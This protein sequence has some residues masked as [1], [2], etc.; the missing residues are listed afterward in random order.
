ME[1]SEPIPQTDAPVEPAKPLDYVGYGPAYPPPMRARSD[2]S[3]LAIAVGV[4]SIV[5]AS[6]GMLVNGYGLSTYVD[7]YR[8]SIPPPPPAPPTPLPPVQF[9][10]YDGDCIGPSGIKAPLRD[11]VLVAWEKSADEKLSN[12]RKAMLHRILADAGRDAFA[13]AE[14]GRIAAEVRE[15]G[16]ANKGPDGEGVLGTQYMITTRGRID[17]NNSTAYF[18]P[19]ASQSPADGTGSGGDAGPARAKVEG[20]VFTNLSGHDRWSAGAIPDALED[21]QT[22]FEGT[23]NGLQ[24][25]AIMEEIKKV[26]VNKPPI[27]SAQAGRGR[28]E[29]NDD[30]ARPALPV[31]QAAWVGMPRVPIG[32]VS[33][34][35]LTKGWAVPAYLPGGFDRRIDPDTGTDVFNPPSFTPRMP[36]SLS[37]L[38]ALAVEA[39]I[40]LL[41]AVYLMFC[42]VITLTRPAAGVR[43]HVPWIVVKAGAAGMCIAATFVF[44]MSMPNSATR[45]PS[46]GAFETAVFFHLI[47]QVVYPVLLAFMLA[48]PLRI[49]LQRETAARPGP[50]G[51]SKLASVIAFALA[52]SIL[53]A[54]SGPIASARRAAPADAGI[55]PVCVEVASKEH[56]LSAE[57]FDAA[58]ADLRSDERNVFF[59]AARILASS[60][61]QGR[62]LVIDKMELSI[63]GD[64]KELMLLLQGSLPYL[65]EI[66]GSR[67]HP[68]WHEIDPTQIGAM[69]RLVRL[70]NKYPPDQ[71]VSHVFGLLDSKDLG[72]KYVVAKVING[73]SL[74]AKVGPYT[75]RQLREPMDRGYVRVMPHPAPSNPPPPPPPARPHPW[76]GL[77][78][79]LVIGVVVSMGAVHVSRGFMR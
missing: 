17:L 70:L 41:L 37:A 51:G 9:G 74:R 38:L 10:P 43:L 66:E 61:Q 13:A 50:A 78:G 56:P 14:P 33:Y 35:V 34:L 79:Y 18:T 59:P 46:E 11:A 55:S 42:G 24:L 21:L 16:R 8:H 57:Q 27:T 73:S 64:Q 63:G 32:G 69:S 67:N 7:G 60:G 40:S 36:G 31:A 77:I 4:M 3:G 19:G 20:D 2:A 44:L 26:P 5:L 47:L 62:S 15:V 54:G 30:S 65:S 52:A 12:D 53:A 22:Q 75:L 25:S 68:I 1:S 28:L 39:G 76:W 71:A 23:L 45:G 29:N 72:V 6:A 49:F 48:G 58:A